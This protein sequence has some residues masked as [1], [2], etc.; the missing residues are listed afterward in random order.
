MPAFLTA[1][2]LFGLSFVALWQHNEIQHINGRIS[3]IEKAAAKQDTIKV[4]T[5]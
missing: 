2:L 1:L 4:Q 3:Q 5:P